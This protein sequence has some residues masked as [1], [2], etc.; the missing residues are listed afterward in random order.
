MGKGNGGIGTG[1]G[2]KWGSRNKEWPRMIESDAK[3]PAKQDP[4][5]PEGWLVRVFIRKSITTNKRADNYWYSPQLGLKFNSRVMVRRFL[6][7]LD[8]AGGDEAK[9]IAD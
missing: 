3:R 4:A 7:V 9:A 2:K 1:K 8:K 5:F 6:Q